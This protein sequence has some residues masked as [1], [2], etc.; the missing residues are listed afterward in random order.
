MAA[1]PSRILLCKSV[2]QIGVPKLVDR[3]RLPQYLLLQ[4]SFQQWHELHS[5]PPPPKG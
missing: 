2:L 5:S 4:G 3:A 1:N